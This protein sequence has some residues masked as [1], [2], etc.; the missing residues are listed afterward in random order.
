MAPYLNAYA[1]SYT[2]CIA[3]RVATIL[4][5]SPLRRRESFRLATVV[6]AGEIRFDKMAALRIYWRDGRS[7]SIIVDRVSARERV[8]VYTG[9]RGILAALERKTP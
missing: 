3:S 9:W 4:T 6:D 2:D 8:T 5:I 7:I 1:I